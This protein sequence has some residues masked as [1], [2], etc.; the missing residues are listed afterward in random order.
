[1]VWYG[2][3]WYGMVWYGMDRGVKLTSGGCLRGRLREQPHP[4]D[5]QP[6]RSGPP[7]R[8]A[9]PYK[10]SATVPQSSPLLTM[11][12]VRPIYIFTYIYIH[13]HIRIYV[14]IHWLSRSPSACQGPSGHHSGYCTNGFPCEAEW[15]LFR[16]HVGLAEY[17]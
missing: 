13:L 12:I 1:M 4:L 15:A 6:D 10:P 16:F 5:L 8:A 14:H 3:V 11:I 17:S 2:M 9:T 7:W